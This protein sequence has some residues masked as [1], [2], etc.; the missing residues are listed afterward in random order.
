MGLALK[1]LIDLVGAGLGL[2]I[3]IIPMAIIALAVAA[4]MGRPVLFRQ[5][6]IGRHG[7]LFDMLKFRTMSDGRGPDGALLPDE[8][9]TPWFGA[10][11]RR[12]RL[13]E[14]PELLT[15][16]NGEMSL[17]GPRPLPPYIQDPHVKKTAEAGTSPDLGAKRATMPPGLTGYAQVCG[18][19]LLT[20]DEKF[21]LDDWYVD[22]WSLGLDLWVMGRTLAVVVTGER[23]DEERIGE[24]RH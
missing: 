22:H 18:G 9:R 5:S 8:Q 7:R 10:F 1:R 13:D 6:R 3:A 11:L 19:T 2:L 20:M 16:L 23:R 15:I 24:A 14:L 4:F 21:A 12:F 17:V